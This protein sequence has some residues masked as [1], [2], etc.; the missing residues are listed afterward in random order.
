M[1]NLRLWNEALHIDTIAF[2]SASTIITQGYPNLLANYK[3]DNDFFLGKF[4]TG[5]INL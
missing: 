3:F 4:A 1:K 2:F 5:I